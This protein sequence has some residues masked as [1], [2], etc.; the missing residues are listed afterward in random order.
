[1][2]L[3]TQAR[4]RLLLFVALL[5]L[6][7]TACAP[8]RIGVS[9]PVVAPL[10]MNGQTRLLVA[11][12][13]VVTLIEPT[14]GS[15][16]QLQTPDGQPR[17]DDSGNPRRWSID[18]HQF[19]NAQFFAAPLQLNDE[20]LLFPAYNNR[21]L[22]VDLLTATVEN[23]VGI[24]LPEP[25]IAQAIL[26]DGLYIVPMKFRNIVAID[27]VSQT[28]AWTF[29][30]QHGIWDAPILVADAPEIGADTLYVASV[31]HN[32]YAIDAATGKRAWSEPVDLE[33]LA[34]ASPLYDDGF[35]YVGSYSHKV[36]K[37][38]TTGEVVGSVEGNDWVWSTPVMY[39]GT[40]YFNDLSGYV[41]AVNPDDMSVLWSV[42]AS[43]RGIRPSPL[44]T[45]E[46]VIVASRDGVVHWLDRA[47]GTTRHSRTI[48]GNPEILSDLLLI[49][50]SATLPIA[51]PLVVVSTLNT[52][53]LVVAFPLDYSSGYPGWAYAR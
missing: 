43:S 14:N 34:G 18:G 7:T 40:L 15:L 28:T 17:V 47:D 42:R 45:E 22:E 6:I 53:R 23:R 4:G 26:T 1:M 10:E 41:Y 5:L 32:L 36:F 33:G 51:E 8:T 20:K 19:D 27:R 46:Y 3:V 50:P 39:A 38:T 12:N 49:E 29:E 48:E 25:T 13:H 37:V 52:A 31:D 11:Y 2:K 44:V 35:L 21:L 9:W 24:P 16:T 30:T